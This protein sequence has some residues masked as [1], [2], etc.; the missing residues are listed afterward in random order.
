MILIRDFNL[1]SENNVLMKK[2]PLD[3]EE[4][5]IREI[6]NFC[7]EVVNGLLIKN[8]KNNKITFNL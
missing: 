3:K 8:G 1:F 6:L 2:I 5:D 7:N 4:C